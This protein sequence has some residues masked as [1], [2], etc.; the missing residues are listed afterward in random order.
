MKRV[1]NSNINHSILL[2]FLISFLMYNVLY[3]LDSISL[4]YFVTITYFIYRFF[5]FIIQV[6]TSHRFILNNL[7]CI[8]SGQPIFYIDQYIKRINL[9]IMSCTIFSIFNPVL[10]NVHLITF[11]SMLISKY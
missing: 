8:S 3:Y 5:L 6:T 4:L 1:A 10:F 11:L 9:S 2:L 7:Y